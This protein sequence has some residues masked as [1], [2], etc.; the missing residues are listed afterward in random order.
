M[1]ESKIPVRF[2]L[3][4]KRIRTVLTADIAVDEAIYDLVDNSVDAIRAVIQDEEHATDSHGLPSDYSGYEVSLEVSRDAVC[5]QDNG[6]GMTEKTLRDESLFTGNQTKKSFGIGHFGV[7]LLRAALKL[8]LSLRLS[9]D[10]GQEAYALNISRDDMESIDSSSQLVAE[11]LSSSGKCGTMLVCDDLVMEAASLLSST[12]EIKKISHSIAVRYALFIRKGLHIRVNGALLDDALPTIQDDTAHYPKSDHRLLESGVNVHT[13]V[14]YDSEYPVDGKKRVATS[15]VVDRSGWYVACNDRVITI[16]DQQAFIK[17][18]GE[19][20]GMIFWSHFVSEDP[21]LMPW[22]SKKSGVNEDSETYQVCKKW[23]MEIAAEFRA[24][25]RKLKTG[26]PDTIKSSTSSQKRRS[27]KERKAKGGVPG[28]KDSPSPSRAHNTFESDL[29]F[30]EG[31]NSESLVINRLLG[32]LGAC[33]AARYPLASTLLFRTVLEAAVSRRLKARH[34]TI[35]RKYAKYGLVRL[36][37][38]LS[39]DGFFNSVDGSLDKNVSALLADK[40]LDKQVNFVA[41]GHTIND[42]DQ[43]STLLTK[44]HPLVEWA[45]EVPKRSRQQQ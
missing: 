41:H 28:A 10:N 43:V 5:I 40:Y 17:K 42:M 19:Y 16:A 31:L 38:G 9:T 23:F 39:G 21:E 2:G 34:T 22:N 3:D 4:T 27:S 32:E 15:R 7:G 25:N 8:G 37:E 26:G 18:H 36:L 20:N 45:F 1:S 35:H 30:I 33:Y 13:K 24:F 44:C 29:R 11:R 6:S 14:G 12:R